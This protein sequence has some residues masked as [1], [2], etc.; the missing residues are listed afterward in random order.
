MTNPFTK[1]RIEFHILQSFPVTCLNRDD[2]GSPKSAIVGG[3][4]R[5][6][7]SS[8]CWKRQVR[9]T[10]R[11]LGMK[12]AVRTKHITDLI[13]QACIEL[14]ADVEKA[15][16]CATKISSLLAKDTLYFLPDSEVKAYAQYAQD[17]SFDLS[18]IDDKAL[19]K[20][21]VKISKKTRIS[22]LD[23]LDLALFGRMVAKAP[24]LNIEAASAFSHAISTHKVNSDLDFFTAL[25]DFNVYTQEGSAHMGSA[26]FNSAT[27]YRYVCLD[28][29]QLAETLGI[30]NRQSPEMQKAIEAFVKA[31]YLAVPEA[32]QN[33]FSGQCG[34]DYAKVFVRKGQPLQFSCDEPVRYDTKKG[35]G[36][37]Q[38][39]IDALNSFLTSKIRMSG[40]LFGKIEEYELS[41]QQ[42]S[43]DELIQV[44]KKSVCYE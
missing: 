10:L 17:H 38:P 28:L 11:D 2:L 18:E 30:E 41:A 21:L 1:T 23:G 32:R 4:T 19:L 8:Q 13:E 27:Y 42:G 14:Q 15:K 37:L 7:V 9:L 6:R 3:V 5:A 31:L 33:T 36:Y 24:E 39:S 25:D 26:E 34:W 12:L 43:I 35:G 40:S 22:A 16:I 29:G 44:L 20:D